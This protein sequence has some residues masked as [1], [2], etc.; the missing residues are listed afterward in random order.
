V[1]S[2]TSDEGENWGEEEDEEECEE[3]PLIV[4]EKKEKV[5]KTKL[6]FSKLKDKLLEED[7][8]EDLEVDAMANAFGVGQDKAEKTEKSEATVP[9]TKQVTFDLPEENNV[10]EKDT[11]EADSDSETDSESESDAEDYRDLRDKKRKEASKT[12]GEELEVVPAQKR[13]KALTAAELALGQQMVSSRKRKNEI[14]DNAYHRWAWGEEDLPDWFADE[15]KKYYQK[16]LPVTKEQVA[17]YK[18][19]IREINARP[20][21]KIAEAKAKQKYKA[22]KKLAKLSEQADLITD[23]T[24]GVQAEQVMKLKQ[25]MKKADQSKKKQETT[26]VKAQRAHGKH[27]KRPP[28]AKG[29]IKF[30]DSRMKKDT[31]GLKRAAAKKKGGP[32]TKIRNR[33]GHKP[34]SR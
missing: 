19:Q 29:K 27:Q 33:V 24:G 13:H 30:V 11:P 31:D 17:E 12:P 6:W 25:M 34:R 7:I 3:N 16:S 8:D 10:A 32:K 15:E 23:N 28:G 2:A 18:Q 20:I 22:M 26:Y 21:K 1:D 5:D 4:E 9:E 14:M